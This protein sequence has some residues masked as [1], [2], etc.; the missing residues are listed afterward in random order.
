M[1]AIANYTTRV[2]DTSLSTEQRQEALK[3]IGEN[4]LYQL[5]ALFL[6]DVGLQ[7]MYA[8]VFTG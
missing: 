8:E 7:I 2:V 6:P 1:S 5:G 3:F 4:Q